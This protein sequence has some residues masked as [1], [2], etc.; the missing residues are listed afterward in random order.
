M[1][2][3][4]RLLAIAK[5]EARYVIPTAYADRGAPAGGDRHRMLAGLR[6]RT[7]HVHHGSGPFGESS[8]QPVPM[9]VESFQALKERQTSEDVG[10]GSGRPLPGEPAELGRQGITGDHVR[11]QAR[12]APAAGRS[13]DA[14]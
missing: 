10:V 2:E 9:A 6:G 4:Y 7:R 12:V 13:G 5:Y 14:R 8:G 11:A 1:Y 3:M